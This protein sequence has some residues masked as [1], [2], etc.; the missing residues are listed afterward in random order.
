MA[1]KLLPAY[2]GTE[3]LPAYEFIDKLASMRRTTPATVATNKKG[4]ELSAVQ[5]DRRLI[6]VQP[7]GQLVAAAMAERMSQTCALTL[8]Q[9]KRGAESCTN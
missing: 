2:D 1:A 5:S 3:Q 9:T 4:E 7:S 6:V 8:R